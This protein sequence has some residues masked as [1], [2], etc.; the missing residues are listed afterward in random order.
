MILYNVT[1][2]IDPQVESEWLDWMVKTHIPEVMAT[3]MFV[4]NNVYKILTQEE[5]ASPSYSIQYFAETM[6]HVE[7]YLSDYAPGLVQK[8]MEKYKDKHVAFR[9]LLE[10]VP[11]EI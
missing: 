7:R 1:V 9:T 2:G 6:D 11:S 3:G 8:H 4:K 5:G 10:E